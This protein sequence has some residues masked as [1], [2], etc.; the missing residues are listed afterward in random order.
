MKLFD[1]FLQNQR[2]SKVS[3][4]L[5][6]GGRFI[7]DVGCGDGAFLLSLN[8]SYSDRYGCDPMPFSIHPHF[9]F[10]QGDVLRALSKIS[11]Q[12]K[13]DVF[14]SMAVFEH[15][16][17]DDIRAAGRA[18][19]QRLRPGGVLIATVPSP[20]VDAILHL[21]IRVGLLS[22]QE[23]HQHWGF[24]PKDLEKH[25]EGYLRLKLRRRFQF[26]LN[27]IFVFEKFN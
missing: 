20:K 16:A 2:I 15:M 26:G 23:S 5:P 10:V 18:I 24:S 19:S 8:G 21:L 9:Y 25:L 6:K 13:F 7:F 17:P 12:I 1:Y 14:T 11:Q 27:N 22:G 3:K 4:Y